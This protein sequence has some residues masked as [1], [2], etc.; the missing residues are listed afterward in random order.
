[1]SKA[2]ELKEHIEAVQKMA[3]SGYEDAPSHQ[4]TETIALA[5][6]H[7]A[8]IVD[9]LVRLERTREIAAEIEAEIEADR[10]AP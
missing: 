3:R 6:L 5:V 10:R 2:K 9:E 8:N 4:Y 1:M 7:L